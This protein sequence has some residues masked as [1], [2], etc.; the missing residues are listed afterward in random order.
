KDIAESG[1]QLANMFAQRS[2]LNAELLKDAK[3]RPADISFDKEYSLDL[4]G[5]TAKIMAVGP[6][7]TLGDTVVLVDGVLFSGDD[8]MR[9]QPSVMAQNAT[10]THWLAT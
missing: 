6:N 3:F 4:G 5:L 2:P 8:A 10:L 9:P 7:H 1:L